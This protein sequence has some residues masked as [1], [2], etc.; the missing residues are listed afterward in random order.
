MSSQ[1][2][3]ESE[4]RARWGPACGA[5]FVVLAVVSVFVNSTPDTN[6]S[7][8]YILAWYNVHSHK[9]GLIISLLLVDIAVV[10]GIFFFGYLRD[11]FG[12]TDLGARLSP[13]LLAGAIILGVGGVIGSGAQ[14]SLIDE[15]KH[16]LPATAQT[17]NFIQSDL[18]AAATFVGVSILM[19]AATVIIWKTRIL[20]IW[21]AGFSL[22][23]AV[24]ALVGPV[25]FFAFALMGIWILIVA[26][27]MWRREETL[28]VGSSS[29]DI[30]GGTSDALP[31]RP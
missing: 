26:F 9:V 10:F 20:P 14:I 5:A 13:V 19:W 8:A 21:L 11:R 2:V 7:P 30:S 24:A 16:M 3:L 27:L 12:R 1:A 29:Q 31:P 4:H 18:N 15:P 28:P 23:L 6:K 25:G 22:V 17:L